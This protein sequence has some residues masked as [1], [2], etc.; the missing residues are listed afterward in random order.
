MTDDR[1]QT[2]DITTFNKKLLQG[3][4]GD[5]FL[6]KSPPGRRR[7]DSLETIRKRL[8]FL[9]QV[10]LGYLHLNRVSASLSAGEAQRVKLAGLLGSGLTSLTVL[11]DEPTRGLHPREVKALVEALKELRDEGN[12][13][14][15]VEHD[16][17][18][19]EEADHIIDIGPFAG[20]GGGRIA[21]QGTP[22]EIAGKDT[23]TG[24]WLRGER[25]CTFR[26]HRRKPKKWIIIKGARENNLKNE[27]IKIPRGVLVGIC[28]VSGSGKSTLLMDTLGRILV[29]VKHTTSV[30]K[31]PLEPGEHDEIIGAPA[32]T[33]LVDQSK[34][35]VQSPAAFLELV[36]PLIKLYAQ[37]E[38]A[39]ALGLDAAALGKRCSVCQGSGLVRLDMGF[40]PDIRLEC[41]TCEG[42]GYTG[43]MREIKLHGHSLPQLNR[44]TIDEVYRLFSDYE[45][46]AGPLKAA[47]EV[48]LGYLV[49]RQPGISLSGGEAQRLK[50]A[51][52]LCKKTKGE[53]LYILDEPTVGQHLEDVNR[54][55]QVLHRLVDE[56]NSVIIIEHHP[57][58]LAACDWL[59]EL[60]PGGGPEGGRVIA[61]GTPE[62]IAEM[63]TP[64]SPY[65]MDV[66]KDV[67][68]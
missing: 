36:Q 47:G 59:L 42:T 4:Q 32:R 25:R 52:Q 63:N 54:L 49:L 27:T 18:I 68:G 48:G 35:G 62:R 16:P 66:L 67:E 38:D 3:V 17:G 12:T 2:T 29:P 60:G 9:E 6:E 20:T 46:I 21:A 11:L 31:E 10:G 44:L 55:S 26:G 45:Q 5:G 23:V 24:A 65:I 43:E 34:K 40:L 50:I 8:C 37:G 14:I 58:L 56:G 57:Y 1:R 30:A 22:R 15:V 41:E 33:L 64:T 51:K 39:R 53:T 19:I 7:Q 28:G 13:V 61:S